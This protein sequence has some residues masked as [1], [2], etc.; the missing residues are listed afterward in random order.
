MRIL[1][2][3]NP[4]SSGPVSGE[5]RVVEN[6]ARLLREHGHHVRRWEPTPA[7]VSGLRLVATGATA[8]WSLQAAKELRRQVERHRAELIHCHN[9]FPSLSPSV[10]RAAHVDGV[11]A[12][13]TL[14]NYRLLCLPATFVRDHR[15]CE[16]CLGRFPW[17]GVRHRCYRNSILAS[18]ALAASHT[19]H[20]L[21]GTYDRVDLF[22]AVSSFLKGKHVEAGWRAEAIRVKPNFAWA[23]KRREG[24]GDYFAYVGRLTA[25][26]GVETLLDVWR[27]IRAKLLIVGDGPDAARLREIAPTGVEFTGAVPGSE[28][29]ALLARAR[30]LLVPSRW[31]EGAPA[32]IPEAYAAGVP[33]IAADI[34]GVAEGVIDGESGFLVGAGG[35]PAWADAVTR[36]QDDREC[37][38]LG[39]GAFAL[40]RSR[41]SPETGIQELEAAYRAALEPTSRF[42]PPPG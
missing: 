13:M 10:L 5:N 6:E 15:I 16:D 11:P 21:A 33:V 25:E 35:T 23:A 24:P 20:R 17:R 2:V 29:P 40:W 39:D 14:H 26:K 8:V 38:R 18:G 9:L 7:G 3:H 34:G 12:V 42:A 22:L 28:V 30:A 36:L 41:Y 37:R 32:V 19:L 27:D 4:Y 31:Y 1:T